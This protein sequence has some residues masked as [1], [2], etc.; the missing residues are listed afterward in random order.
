MLALCGDL[1]KFSHAIDG[2][3]NNKNW[4]DGGKVALSR[5][6]RFGEVVTAY[7]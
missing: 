4:T 6:Y 5:K 3:T 7:A 2:T 1:D